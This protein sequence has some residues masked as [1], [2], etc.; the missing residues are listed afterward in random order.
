MLH[1]SSTIRSLISLVGG[2]DRSLLFAAT[3]V[4]PERQLFPTVVRND[5]GDGY[6]GPFFD[7]HSKYFVRAAPDVQE[8]AT[9]RT[10]IERREPVIPE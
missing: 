1:L 3:N 2:V 8:I 9:E 6:R 4:I 7:R 5:V 10:G